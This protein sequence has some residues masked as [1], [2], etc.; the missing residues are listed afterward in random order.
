MEGDVIVLQDLFLFDFGMGVDDDGRFLG[1]LKATGI[2]PKFAE[3]LVRLRHPPRPRGVR[4]RTVRPPRRRGSGEAPRVSAA[5][6]AR[7]GGPRRSPGPA[8]PVRPARPRAASIVRNVDTRDLPDGAP[9]GARQ[10]RGA[11]PHRLHLR[12][13]G[14]V[15]PDGNLEV[16]PLKQ[17]A[18]PVGTV[19]VID[20]SGSMKSRIDQAK[21]AARQFIAAKAPN[22]WIAVV[23]FSS[24]AVLRSDFTQDAR[25][26][27]GRRRRPAGHR[28][29]GPVGRVDDRRPALRQASRAPAQRRA[30]LRRRRHHLV[31][32]RGA[33][34]R[35]A[36]R[37]P[38][39]P[40]SPSAIASPNSSP[41]ALQGLVG[42]SGGSLRP[43]PTRRT[44]PPSSPRSAQAIENQ[45]EVM[46]PVGRQRRVADPRPGGRRSRRTGS[47]PGPGTVGAAASP[48][49][50]GAGGGGLLAARRSQVR[51]SS[52]MALLAAGLLAF[53]LLRRSS[54]SGEQTIDD[55]LG[56]YGRRPALADEGERRRRT[57]PRSRA[58]CP[59]G[60]RASHRGWRTAAACWSR[61]RGCWSR[62]TSRCGRP[63]RCSSTAPAWSSSGF[64][65]SSAR[66]RLPVGF[67]LAADRGRCA[68]WSCVQAA[69]QAAAEG[70]RGA[71]ARHP[72]PP[73][74]VAAGRLLLPPGLEAVA[75]ETSDPM[76]RE[77]RRVLAEARL[78]R[79]L[80][81]ALARRRRPHGEPRLRLGRAWPSGSSGRSAATWPSCSRRWPRRW[82]SGAGCGAR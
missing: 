69:A 42:G 72:Q 23:S 38:T 30:A 56:R 80:E 48:T 31:G 74:R 67:M 4:R 34:G 40:S 39:P 11:K 35:G 57:S 63:R 12:E 24:Q 81:E 47:R 77:L 17:T 22:E 20:T 49:V 33:G 59:A 8:R 18:K 3:K 71:A 10:R 7:A 68:R 44:C 45:F 9:R 51:A 15:V 73:G 53:A 6:A 28:R 16:R 14:K 41:P 37:P 13:N 54:A 62:P 32:H 60:G 25:R 58:A 52:L 61:W 43:A 50:V 78:G 65:P 26:P 19:L 82:S 66:R 46:L 2:R 55:R 27:D 36:R 76:A 21:A 5:L 1:H 64:W 75:Q 29:D 70:V 79:P